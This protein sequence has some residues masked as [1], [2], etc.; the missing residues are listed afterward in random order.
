MLLCYVSAAPSPKHSRSRAQAAA[1]GSDT[2]PQR[3]TLNTQHSTNVSYNS[4]YPYGFHPMCEGEQLCL[5]APFPKAGRLQSATASSSCPI[6]RSSPSSKAT[7]PGADIWRASVRVFDAAVE[8]AYGGKR[9]IGWM[10]VLRRR[11]GLHRNGQLAAR[12][13]GRGLQRLPGRHQGPAHHADRRRHPL[14]Q[15]RPA[16]DA[17]PLRLPAAGALLRRRPLARQAPRKGRHGHLP[18]EHRGHLR[19]HR[20]PRRHPRGPEGARLPRARASRRTSTRS[21]SA[22]PRRPTR[23]SP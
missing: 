10:E 15:R 13:H 6:T 1:S 16:P 9:K 3:S 7:A 21:A 14:A 22:P 5:E 12:R 4:D 11:E 23:S 8:K 17:R 19:G 2:G 20:I 18:R